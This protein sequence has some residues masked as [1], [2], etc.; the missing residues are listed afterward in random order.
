MQTARTNRRQTTQHK[1]IGIWGKPYSDILAAFNPH[2]IAELI[3]E[4]PPV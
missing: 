4:G 2:M 3:R 1:L